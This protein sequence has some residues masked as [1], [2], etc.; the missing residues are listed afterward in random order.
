MSADH[1]LSLIATTAFGLEKVVAR[2][3]QQLG[4]TEQ[5]VE[6]G[7]VRFSG[8]AAAICRANLWLRSADRV[9]VEVGDF[10]C[11]DFGELFD[12][13]AALPWEQWLA[14]DSQFPVRGRSVRSTLAS[15]PDCQRLVKKA[16]ATRL[17]R[18]YDQDWCPETG[19]EYTIE[20]AVVNDR[21]L[22]TI[23]TSGAGLHKRGYRTLVG[24]APLRET[25]AAALV[26]LS[27]WNRERPFADPCCGSGTI[28]IEA[29]LIGRNIAPGLNRSFAAEDWPQIPAAVWSE[30]RTE[31][32]DLITPPLPIRMLATDID[33]RALR[34]ARPHAEAAGVADDIHFQTRPLAEF[35]SSRP[36]GCLITNPPYGERL[37]DS[38][39]L[40]S[41]YGDMR[42]AF[43]ELEKWS[44]YVLT[45]DP[46]FE[47]H[48]ERKADRRRKLYNARI[49]CTYY[50][51]YGPRPPKRTGEPPTDEASEQTGE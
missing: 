50:Q 3:L 27:Y 12:Q 41:L 18:I 35:S 45:A 25:L 19:P 24:A 26:Q 13:T 39:T 22:L 47:R 20:I 37:G 1:N 29:A 11:T 9:L 10:P 2:E 8:D 51:F 33:S 32:R 46:Q 34:L 23:D 5:Q 21:A 43:G 6:N 28:P 38:D 36:Y 31:A 49:A 4:Y 7:R 48:I 17:Q 44:L 30:A 16:I 40:Q 42:R 14:A 15:V